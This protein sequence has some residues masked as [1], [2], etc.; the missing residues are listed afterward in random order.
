M[1]LLPCSPFV[2]NFKTLKFLNDLVFHQ[3]HPMNMYFHRR[4]MFVLYKQI[5]INCMI[6]C[7]PFD[8]FKEK[9]ILDI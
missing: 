6:L 7:L 2:Q 4:G 8:Y 3:F 5:E 9:C 1:R